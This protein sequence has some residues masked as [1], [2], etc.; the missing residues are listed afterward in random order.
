M[1]SAFRQPHGGVQ[2]RGRFLGPETPRSRTGGLRMTQGSSELSVLQGATA[3][4]QFALASITG[5]CRTANM[6]L[7]GVIEPA[8]FVLLDGDG[9]RDGLKAS[10]LVLNVL[11]EEFAAERSNRTPRLRPGDSLPIDPVIAA[12]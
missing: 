5:R 7:Y 4:A 3:E 11:R 2:R 9:H 10:E 8:V 6:D 12:L 1:D